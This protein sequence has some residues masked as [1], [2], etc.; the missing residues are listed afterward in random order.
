MNGF[1]NSSEVCVCVC[2]IQSTSSDAEEEEEE[3]SLRVMYLD[4][5]FAGDPEARK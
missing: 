2:V 1:V 3:V 5:T 4:A